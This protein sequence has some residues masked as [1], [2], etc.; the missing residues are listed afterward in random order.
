MT[1][2]PGE[3]CSICNENINVTWICP[4]CHQIFCDDCVDIAVKE[5]WVCTECGSKDYRLDR[6]KMPICNQC[7][8]KHF[9]ELKNLEYSCRNCGSQEIIQIEELQNQLLMEYKE[10]IENCRQFLSPVEEVVTQ[11]NRN[12]QSLIQLRSDKPQ[13]YH[14]PNLEA[15]LILAIQ[16]FQNILNSISEE[17]YHFFQEI[18]RNIH[19][20]SEIKT[21]HASNLLLIKEIIHHFEI[22]RQK[23]GSST[24]SSLMQLDEK[25]IR[26]DEKIKFME[27]VRSQ[28][29]P[30][31]EKISYDPDEKMVYIAKCKLSN[32]T[33]KAGSYSNKN[34]T[35]LLSSKR[36]YFLQET[37]LFKKRTVCL[38]Q[39]LLS[40]VGEYKVKGKYNQKITFELLNE[41]YKF[42]IPKNERDK[43]LEWIDRAKKF[44]TN[45]VIDQDGQKKLKRIK[46]NMGMFQEELE[47]AIFELIGYHGY[48]N[49]G[50]TNMGNQ[51]INGQMYRN[52]NL[53]GNLSGNSKINA[54]SHISQG[55][56]TNQ[57]QH[58]N[59]RYSSINQPIRQQSSQYP[60]YDRNSTYFPKNQSVN[61]NFPRN[62]NDN[63]NS[64]GKFQTHAGHFGYPHDNYD[65]KSQRPAGSR[66][67]PQSHIQ[68]HTRS[69]NQPQNRTQT[70][71]QNPFQVN[72]PYMCNSGEPSENSPYCEQSFTQNYH[73]S[74]NYSQSHIQ[75]QSDFQN[76]SVFQKQSRFQHQQPSPMRS[77]IPWENQRTEGYQESNP[78][79]SFS[80]ADYGPTSGFNN[81]IPD[82]RSN[83]SH[84]QTRYQSGYQMNHPSKF[85]NGQSSFESEQIKLKTEIEACE[86]ELNSIQETLKMLQYQHD[87]NNISTD[88]F[89]RSYSEFQ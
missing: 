33:N 28:I 4:Q 2:Y 51:S 83:Q 30:L 59:K 47:Q 23:V 88:E 17:V 21:T 46:I 27:S 49:I 43:L 36:L 12:R 39:I 50:F 76:Q 70:R 58:F 71:V 57:N 85:L 80:N 63:V 60:K 89:I 25:L 45:Y 34:G 42:S 37:G 82:Q 32:G 10:I 15:E 66:F 19:Y 13:F 73:T 77:S 53:P 40:D 3:V 54:A 48:N 11:L 18:E 65:L 26:I 38:F 52:S 22:N 75:H 14:Y 78:M 8:S 72:D 68:H 35:V 6:H 64:M 69:F 1:I 61:N 74:P 62:Q 16:F 81:Y 87:S 84:Y 5:G 7:G 86:A 79:H 24:K 67:Q 20:I 9:N 31:M 29:V 56:Y 44:D 41:Y 55:R